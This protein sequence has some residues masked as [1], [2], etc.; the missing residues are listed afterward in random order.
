MYYNNKKLHKPCQTTRSLP[1][2]VHSHST[3]WDRPNSASDGMPPPV[4]PLF[5]VMQSPLMV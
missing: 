4:T 5:V 3:P 1:Y 2:V